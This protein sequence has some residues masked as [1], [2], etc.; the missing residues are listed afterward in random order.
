MIS[1]SFSW[2]TICYGSNMEQFRSPNFPVITVLSI[3]VPCVPVSPDPALVVKPHWDPRQLPLTFG[4]PQVIEVL[5][6]MIF[7]GSFSPCIF[8]GDSWEKHLKRLDGIFVVMFRSTEIWRK[9]TGD[10]K[11][12]DGILQN[13]ELHPL[14]WSLV[15]GDMNL[16]SRWSRLD[17][18]FFSIWKCTA[19]RFVLI[20][21]CHPWSMVMFLKV[22]KSLVPLRGPTSPPL[23]QSSVDICYDE[24]EIFGL[25]FSLIMKLHHGINRV[26]LIN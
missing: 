5:V 18:D 11:Y 12:F 15:Q 3:A 21:S 9:T 22:K 8:L 1:I 16:L 10:S 2:S 14:R 13:E 26:F 4:I 23:L 20:E 24:D 17:H 25:Y 7:L 6:G 19:M